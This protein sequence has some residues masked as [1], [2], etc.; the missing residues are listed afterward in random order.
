MDIPV[1]ISG[2]ARLGTFPFVLVL[3]SM[4]IITL[5]MLVTMGRSL[6]SGIIFVGRICLIKTTLTERQN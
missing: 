1:M 3:T 4:T 5:T 6:C 2:L